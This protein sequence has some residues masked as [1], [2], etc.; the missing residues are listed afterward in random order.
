MIARFIFTTGLL[1]V[2]CLQGWAQSTFD[3][4]LIVNQRKR[5]F[6]LYSEL[7]QHATAIRTVD[8]LGSEIVRTPIK[9]L[10]GEATF[11]FELSE[12]DRIATIRI[13]EFWSYHQNK[14][15][16]KVKDYIVF[17]DENTIGFDLADVSRHAIDMQ[18]KQ[19]IDFLFDYVA[20]NKKYNVVRPRERNLKYQRI[21]FKNDA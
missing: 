7:M 9:G 21:R 15:D 12:D 6:P 2:I 16:I 14:K 17:V 10:S 3:Q 18:S 5:L 11:I 20:K 1:L 19:I 13:T 8:T 4:R